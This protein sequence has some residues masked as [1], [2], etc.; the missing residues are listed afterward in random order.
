[1]EAVFLMSGCKITGVV[2]GIGA[3]NRTRDGRSVQCAII[4]GDDHG[5][6]RVYADYQGLMSRLSIW[7]RVVCDVHIHGGDSRT[8]SWKLDYCKVVSKITTP[9]QKRDILESC[10]LNCGDEDPIDWMNRERRSVGLIK[11]PIKNIGY[12]MEVRDFEDSPD[13]VMTQKETPQRPTIKWLSTAG[14]LH[15]HQLC[16]HEAYEWLR[17]NPSQ[18]SQLW[19]NLRIEDIDYTKWLLLGNTNGKRNVWVVVHVHRLKKTT[20]QPTLES[21]EITDGRPN[22]WPYLPL[23][24]LRAMRVASTGQQLLFTT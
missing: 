4:L 9:S 24:D 10:L 21:C 20:H 16:A 6:C 12:A 13:W 1:M 18:T 8:E 23:G 15:N 14:K 3:P 7:E 17:K 2:L 11:A 22:G 5:L 19:C